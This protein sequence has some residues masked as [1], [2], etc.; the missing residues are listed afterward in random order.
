[1]RALLTGD[2]QSAR[3]AAQLLKLGNGNIPYLSDDGEINIPPDFGECV[4]NLAALKSEVYP[5][6]RNNITDFQWMRDRAILAPKN[7]VVD[8]LNASL[9]NEMSGEG[10]VYL[11]FDTALDTESA[12]TFSVEFLNSQR[13]S[14]L[15]AHRLHLKVG[16]PVMCIRNL[17]EFI[18]LSNFSLAK[19]SDYNF[20]QIHPAFATAPDW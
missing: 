3:F 13:P 8:T 17:G 2:L 1:M 9:L 19:R 4:P 14:G 18:I 15:P 12:A 10:R 6:L 7:T 16:C 11:S 20:V 5:D